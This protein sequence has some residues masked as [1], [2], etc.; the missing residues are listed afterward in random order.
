MFWSNIP[1]Y[2]LGFQIEAFT[3]IT[4]TAT[5]GLSNWGLYRNHPYCSAGFLPSRLVPGMSLS[6]S[7]T[8]A[9]N[10]FVAILKVLDLSSSTSR[11]C[12][13]A[14]APWVVHHYEFGVYKLCKGANFEF[15]FWTCGRVIWIISRRLR[16]LELDW[17]NA[18]QFLSKCVDNT[19]PSPGKC[20][21]FKCS[22]FQLCLWKH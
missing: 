18:M 2:K 19:N 21:F 1:L 17:C 7:K 9:V 5:A 13:R 8:G 3:R 10:V 20:L 16:A 15:W 6:V 12:S 22:N 4:P 11:S 14:E